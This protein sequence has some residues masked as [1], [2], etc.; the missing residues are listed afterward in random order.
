[1]ARSAREPHP[2]PE[3]DPTSVAGDADWMATQATDRP[4]RRPRAG[5]AERPE[6]RA[7]EPEERAAQ[8]EERAAQPASASGEAA[9]DEEETGTEQSRPARKQVRKTRGR[10]SVPSWDE[11]MFGGGGGRAD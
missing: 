11:I 6:E 7:A 8:P 5:E 10:A 9:G 2:H 1:M 4:A 3:V